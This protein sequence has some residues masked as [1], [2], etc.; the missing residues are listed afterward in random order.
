MHGFIFGGYQNILPA[1][2]P[3]CTCP[4]DACNMVLAWAI[5]SGIPLI[6]MQYNINI[7]SDDMIMSN[8]FL[9]P[10]KTYYF[11][12]RLRFRSQRIKCFLWAYSWLRAVIFIGLFIKVVALFFFVCVYLCAGVCMCVCAC[13]HTLTYALIMHS[14]KF[15]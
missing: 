6:A 3:Y 9:C 4:T 7:A 13:V 14:Y 1:L 15:I 2:G 8:F 12:E 5:H 11:S 10:K